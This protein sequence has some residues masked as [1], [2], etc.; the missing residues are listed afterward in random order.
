[1]AGKNWLF[2]IDFQPVFADP[3]SPWFTP[4]TREIYPRLSPLVERWFGERVLF[5]RFVPPGDAPQG[6]WVPYYRDWPFAL[7]ADPAI[8][9]LDAPWK[10]GREI[11]AATFHKWTD[12]ARQ[13]LR[14]ADEI[15]VGGVSTDCCVLNTVMA[16]LDDG[17][18]LRLLSDA[19]A[20]GTAEIHDMAVALM[21]L[22]A[23]QLRV[24]TIA[25]AL[26]EG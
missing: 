16:A 10:G 24:S 26:A 13:I 3:A 18:H 7:T 1:M 25:E 5:T 8:W 2:L 15:V 6:S 11:A 22:R 4:G 12:E 23:P 9:E 14:D 17:A 21:A 20:A 19:C